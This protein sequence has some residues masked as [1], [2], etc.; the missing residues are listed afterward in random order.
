MLK[1]LEDDAH[2]ET[3][4]SQYEALKNGKGKYL[5]K[6]F[7][8]GKI[9][10]QNL[11]LNKYSL[12]PDLSIRQKVIDAEGADLKT[13]GKRL[14][15]LEGK[16]GEL[17]FRQ[18]FGLFPEEL[19]PRRRVGFKAYDGINNT[20]NLAYTILFWKCYRA[21]VKA[22]LEPYLGFLHHI[23][24]GRASLVCD[25]VE[26]YRYLIDDFLIHYCQN[27]KPRDFLAKT[28][29]FNNKKGKRV[30]LKT[31]LT[32]ELTDSLNDYFRR[33]VEVP[34]VKIGE[35]QELETL[36]D[37]EALLMG[38]YLRGEKESWNPRIALHEPLIQK[39]RKQARALLLESPV[40]SSVD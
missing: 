23:Q 29:T 3:R 10:G 7:V 14:V 21:L 17:Y 38:K 19:R 30:Y 1:N 9:D 24:Y 37:E 4:I 40:K 5:A 12:K 15:G 31:Y 36:I 13:L 27:L 33:T 18:V 20:F 25:F 11:L 2:V 32:N 8:L 34:R 35:R 28:E 6:Q 16:S 26:L 22:H 39:R